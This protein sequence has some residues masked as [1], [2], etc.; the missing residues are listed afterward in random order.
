M[1]TN[2]STLSDSPLHVGI[3]LGG[4]KTEAILLDHQGNEL[5]RQRISTPRGHY[6]ALLNHLCQFIDDFTRHIESTWTLGIGTP[7]SLGNDGLMRNANTVELIGQPFKADLESALA[8]SVFLENDANC[9]ALSEAFDGAAKYG[10]SVFGAILGTGV[11][12][13]IV[14]NKQ[15]LSGSNKICGEWGHISL[16]WPTQDEFQQGHYSSNACYCGRK[17]CIETYLSGPG[18]STTYRNISGSQKTA[19]EIVT[20]SEHGDDNAE[21]AIQ[22]YEQQLA[23]SLAMTINLFDPDVIVLG[24]GL[25]KVERLYT[26]VPALWNQ[27]IFSDTINTRLLPPRHGDSSGVRGAA[28]LGH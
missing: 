28:L 2:D 19:E 3:D 8:R 18:L 7:G 22:S 16:P 12:G 1:I 17:G 11:G 9:F 4:T 27:Y 13:G 23:K 15:L 24:G 21:K 14:I 10:H 26:S 20:L 6:Q 5:N 25:S